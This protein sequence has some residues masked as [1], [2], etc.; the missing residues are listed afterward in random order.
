[1]TSERARSLDHATC[2]EK[3]AVRTLPTGSM[4]HT[5][6][7][8]LA[9]AL[10]TP[11]L[12]LAMDLRGTPARS[13]A[14]AILLFTGRLLAWS[15]FLALISWLAARAQPYQGYVPIWPSG[16]VGLALLWRHGARYW[17]A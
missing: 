9:A 17:P 6:S 5:V 7:A 11:A 8:L 13:R 14:R 16:G 4:P 12:Y 15:V 1:M 3:P 2:H 10:K